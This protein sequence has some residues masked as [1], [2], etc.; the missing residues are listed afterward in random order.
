[1]SE[2]KET[3][4]S[5]KTTKTRTRRTTRKAAAPAEPVEEIIMKTPETLEAE[6]RDLRLEVAQERTEERIARIVQNQRLFF[7]T[8][9]TLDVSWRIEQLKKL[10]TAIELNEEALFSAL[11]EDLSKSTYESYFCEVGLV[12]HEISCHI[13]NIKKWSKAKRIRAD[14]HL[15]PAHFRLHPEPR[16]VT[17]IMSTWNYPLLLSLQ[18]LVAAMSAG[19]T[20][21]IKTSEYSQATNS[22]IDRIIAQT[23]DENYVTVVQGGYTENRALLN[24]HFDFIM[25]T[26][27]QNVGKIVMTSAARFLTPVCLELGGKSPCIVDASANIPLAAKRII[28]G[29]FL[30]AGQTCVAPDYVLVEQEVKDLLLACLR[31]EVT[32]QFGEHPLENKDYPKIINE[33][34]FVHLST[35]YP[36][37][38][39]DFVSNKIAPTVIDLCNI[40]DPEIDASRLMQEEIFGP[41]LPV[42]SYQNI[43]EV[44]S[45]VNS[46]TVPLALYIFSTDKA[47]QKQ[48]CS[49]IRYGGGCINDVVCHIASSKVPFGGMGESGM[50]AYHGE[51]GFKTFSHYKSI[52][53]QSPKLELNARYALSD[54]KSLNFIKKFLK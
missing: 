47:T 51:Y 38:Q 52:M 25:F 32:K 36:D 18:P 22:V 15:Q 11:R 24:Q 45:Y 3:K 4:T 8:G 9:Q 27:S 49:T 13:H 17:L 54:E 31:E 20:A 34:H 12:L 40:R 30:N 7:G 43:S 44:V 10:H 16:G 39:M 2:E 6:Q 48:V 35:L 26:G 23:F 37:A 46:H 53:V 5:E 21:I 42:I 28:W 14:L 29:K 50:G 19:N 41:F 1:M 33:R